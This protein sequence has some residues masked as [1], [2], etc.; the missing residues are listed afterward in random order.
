MESK[1]DFH[2][3]FFTHKGRVIQLRGVNLSGSTKQ[4]Y[5][6]YSPS[7]IPLFPSSSVSPS[8]SAAS[9][10]S[11]GSPTP[12][13]TTQ[14]EIEN[15]MSLIN[16]RGEISFVGRPFPLSEAHTHLKRL[17]QW[18]FNLLR[19]TVTWEAIEHSA[20]GVYDEEYIN[21]VVEVLKV[22]KIYGFRVFIDPHQDVWSRFTG[23][24]GAPLWTLTKVGFDVTNFKET[25]AALIHSDVVK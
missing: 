17:K 6:P 5:S 8:T 25:Y 12:L 16:E 24:S 23:G 21:Y 13:I 4:P 2:G 10:T 3:R 11:N 22:A 20:P 19:F 1:L 9:T 18:G 7:H 14:S 15:Q